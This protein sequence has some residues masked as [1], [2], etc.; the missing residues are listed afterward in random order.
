VTEI[1]SR[2]WLGDIVDRFNSMVKGSPER[3]AALASILRGVTF[4]CSSLAQRPVKVT[5][6]RPRKGERAKNDAAGNDTVTLSAIE[7]IEELD[8]MTGTAIHEAAHLIRSKRDKNIP[9]SLPIFE[10]AD[11]LATFHWHKFFPPA[12]LALAR[13]HGRWS[14]GMGAEAQRTRIEFVGELILAM[15]VLEDLRNDEWT[16]ASYN[17]YRGYMRARLDRAFDTLTPI[18]QAEQATNGYRDSYWLQLFT[19]R[20]PLHDPDVLPG[21]REMVEIIDEPNISRYDATD[22]DSRWRMWKHEMIPAGK[23]VL[24]TDLPQM[25]QDALAILTLIYE[26][27]KV[28]ESEDEAEDIE[29]RK[30]EYQNVVDGHDTEPMDDDE[31]ETVEVMVANNVSMKSVESKLFKTDVMII[32]HINEQLMASDAFPFATGT[33]GVC[34]VNDRTQQAVTDGQTFGMMLADQLQITGEDNRIDAL[35][36]KRGKIDKRQ[37]AGAGYGSEYLFKRTE[38][39]STDPITL[40]V[41]LD[42]SYSMRDPSDKWTQ[43]IKVASAL[44]YCGTVLPKLR[45]IINIRGGSSIPHVATLFDSAVDSYTHVTSLWPFLYAD[46]LTP[47]GLVFEALHDE[48]DEL[49]HD[50]TRYFVNLSDG[51]PFFADM[52]EME[53]VADDKGIGFEEALKFVPCYMD[54]DAVTHTAGE[55]RR[56]DESGVRI[57]S[58]FIKGNSNVPQSVIDSFHRMYGDGACFIDPTQVWQVAEAINTLMTGRE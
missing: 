54:D 8:A 44:A 34:E 58:F 55:V 35:R 3:A 36:V 27:A 29:Q 14:D 17:G 48:M 15:N 20:H 19:T 7:Y 50:T 11:D 9:G 6:H 22:N 39:E 45:V 51:M 23:M 26:H 56:M 18:L 33:N 41:S 13:K 2:F 37:L 40:F 47:E 30:Q 24:P 57:L 12:L 32:P 5:L 38:I 49:P 28:P 10:F 31:A 21:L 52:D 42:G 43:T 1:I 25:V 16:W 4:F 53:K 46:G